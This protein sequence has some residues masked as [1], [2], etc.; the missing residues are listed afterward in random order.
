MACL[1]E[2][3]SPETSPTRPEDEPSG[4]TAFTALGRAARIWV[5]AVAFTE[6]EVHVGLRPNTSDNQMDGRPELIDENS[7]I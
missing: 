4:S 6:A 3:T 7:K 5:Q 2:M 1:E